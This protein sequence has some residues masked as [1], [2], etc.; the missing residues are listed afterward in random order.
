M[1]PELFDDLI[2]LLVADEVYLE[3]DLHFR[4]KGV[5]PLSAQFALDIQMLFSNVELSYIPDNALRRWFRFPLLSSMA[6]DPET[7]AILQK[8]YENFTL[9]YRQFVEAGG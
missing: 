5:H 8:G 1:Q 2:K 7:R 9:F 4:A 6:D 3:P